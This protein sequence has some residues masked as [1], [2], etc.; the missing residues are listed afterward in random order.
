MKRKTL[1]LLFL[2]FSSVAFYSCTDEE[3]NSEKEVV[4]I[5]A[6]W[7]DHDALM[8]AVDRYVK[9]E[10][11]AKGRTSIRYKDEITGK[12][13]SLTP[14]NVTKE[15]YVVGTEL[16]YYT[17]IMTLSTGDTAWVDVKMIWKSELKDKNG[18]QGDFQ[19]QEV[20]IR[21]IANIARY[22]WK[23]DGKYY[24]KYPVK[25]YEEQIAKLMAEKKAEAQNAKGG[26][27]GMR[28]N[29]DKNILPQMKTNEDE[30]K[31]VV[32][33]DGKK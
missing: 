17:N 4:S 9:T 29:I 3:E 6:R 18:K 1:Y 23:K 21:K 8:W 32:P 25:E 20:S 28:L 27:A 30:P 22:E 12:I 10:V 2:L 15:V 24:E 31:K 14:V 7:D 26:K 11:F 13:W 16:G 19:V 33:I 5:P